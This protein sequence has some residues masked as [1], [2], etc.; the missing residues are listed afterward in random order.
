MKKITRLLQEV[1]AAQR[2]L[3]RPAFALIRR[4]GAAW[5]MTVNL[6]GGLAEHSEH[7][8]EKAAKTHLRSRYPGQRVTIIIDDIPR[9]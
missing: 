4:K 5:G 1:R 2:D 9:E 7:D 6:W 3:R 8:A